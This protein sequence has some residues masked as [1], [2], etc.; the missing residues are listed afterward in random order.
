MAKFLS[1]SYSDEHIDKFAEHLHM[2]NFKRSPW[3]DAEGMRE[4]G[5]LHK[6]RGSFIRKGKVGDWKN[7]STPDMTAKFDTSEQLCLRTGDPLNSQL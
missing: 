5:A 1:K 4:S 3:V 7:H 2:D 6:D